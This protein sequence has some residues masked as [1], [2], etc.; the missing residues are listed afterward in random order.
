MREFQLQLGT[1]NLGA[2]VGVDSDL[3]DLSGPGK[4]LLPQ[5]W[6]RKCGWGT[7]KVSPAL[8]SP[9]SPPLADAG[10]SADTSS[11]LLLGFYLWGQATETET[12]DQTASPS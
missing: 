10:L 11:A 9:H 2:Q 7:E 5:N 1:T 4:Q 8:R 6:Q 12:S 3:L